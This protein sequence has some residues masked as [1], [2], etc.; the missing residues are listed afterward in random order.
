MHKTQHPAPKRNRTAANIKF[1]QDSVYICEAEIAEGLEEIARDELVQRLR[2]VTQLELSKSAVRF[3]FRGNLKQLLQLR[4]V[5][6][7]YLVHRF[8]VPR[9]R[10]LLGHEHLQE[11]QKHIATARSLHPSQA[12]QTL[13]VDAAGSDSSVMRRLKEELATHTGLAIAS[14]SGDLLLRLRRPPHDRGGW[15]TLVRLSPRP[16][17]TRKWRV[18]N[19]EGALNATVAHA[20]VRLS[21]PKADDRFVNIVCGSATILIE[22]L[23]CAPARKMIGCDISPTSLTCAHANIIESQ[24]ADAINLVLCDVQALPLTDSSIDALCA[25]LPFGQLMGS[26]TQ[27]KILYPAIMQEAARVAKSGARFIVITHEVRLMD[28][29]LHQS[30]NWITEQVL[31][32]TLRGLHPRIFV[33]RRR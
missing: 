12:Y 16:L 29:V 30:P 14:D 4:T 24:Y 8:Q 23:A 2:D 15:E 26:H 6:A 10:A 28:T 20:M 31:M 22:R 21:N 19:L 17:A 33:L 9:P 5:Q 13:H 27:N 32:V 11:L 18:C 1:S 3:E 7:V 25:D